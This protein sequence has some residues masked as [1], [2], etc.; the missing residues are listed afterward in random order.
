MLAETPKA[1]GRFFRAAVVGPV[2]ALALAPDQ[3]GW[4]RRPPDRA[5]RQPKLCRPGRGQPADL[6]SLFVCSRCMPTP[7]IGPCLSARERAGSLTHHQPRQSL[8]V[9]WRRRDLLNNRSTAHA[10]GAAPGT[11]GQLRPAL[12]TLVHSSARCGELPLDSA[13]QIQFAQHSGQGS[14]LSF[15]KRAHRPRSSRRF[16]AALRGLRHTRRPWRDSTRKRDLQPCSSLDVLRSY[17][18]VTAPK[19]WR[20]KLR[21]FRHIDLRR[22]SAM[23]TR[24]RSHH[25]SHHDDARWISND[26]QNTAR[27]I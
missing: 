25:R 21:F 7:V 13:G 6:L 4:A 10:R 22:R 5:W 19:V 1:G 18:L 3:A 11:L 26:K 16:A 27:F 23:M 2:L 8:A 24:H 14:C 20:R 9:P 15:G 12:A 17:S